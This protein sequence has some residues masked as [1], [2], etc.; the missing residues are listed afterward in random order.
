M[1]ILV[2]G[3][4]SGLGNVIVTNF[5]SQ[6]HVVYFTYNTSV[7]KAKEIEQIHNKAKG[8]FCNFKELDSVKNFIKNIQHLKIDVLINNAFT[9][10]NQ[11]FFYKSN[12]DSFQNSFINNVVPVLLITQ[13]IIKKFKKEKKGKIITILSS[14]I[15]GTPPEGWSTYVANKQYLL[16][17][18]KSWAIEHIKSNI[19]SNT[20]SPSFLLTPLNQNV[21]DR[22]IE[23]MKRNHP[24][25]ELLTCQEVYNSIEYLVNTSSHINGINLVINA[26]TTI[27]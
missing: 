24:L 23:N 16:S 26:G 4:A 6:H 25:K 20:I 11:D 14:A 22:I 13:E 12:S 21:D 15:I 19:T 5:L 7:E 8:F 2:T 9:G 3:G 18:S 27:S 1:N 17:M 10:F